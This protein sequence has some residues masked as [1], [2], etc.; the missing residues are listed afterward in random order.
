MFD[1]VPLPVSEIRLGPA[2]VQNGLVHA[3]YSITPTI[4]SKLQTARTVG[5]AFQVMYGAPVFLGFKGMEIGEGRPKL[6]G[7]VS[8]CR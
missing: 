3:S 5:I 4:L 2:T 6:L 7:V 8:S 1:G